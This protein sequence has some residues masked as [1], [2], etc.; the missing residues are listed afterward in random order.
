MTRDIVVFGASAGGIEA[1]QRVVGLLPRDLAASFFVVV[2]IPANFASQLARILTLRGGI[3]AVQVIDSQTFEHGCI[4][5]AP[6]DQHLILEKDRVLVW[7]GPKEDRQRPAINPLFRSAAVAYGERV[8]AVVLSG[9]LID[10]SAGVWWVKRYG[11]IAIV[12][13]ASSAA[14]PDMP[15]SVLDYV[16][17]DYILDPEE[18][19]HILPSLVTQPIKMESN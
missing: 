4:Y 3:P 15:M 1:L 6:P 5:V 12:Q 7:H 17:A 16:Q 9:A 2:H 13:S 11:G 10:G 19:G 14:F 18:I 8:I